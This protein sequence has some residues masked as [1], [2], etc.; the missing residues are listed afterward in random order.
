M[1]CKYAKTR[2]RHQR[3][4]FK[5]VHLFCAAASLH[6]PQGTGPRVEGN[7]SAAFFR[8]SCVCARV[9]PPANAE[10]RS[11]A[12][13]TIRHVC[14]LQLALRRARLFSV[15]NERQGGP[16]HKITHAPMAG[17]DGGL[18][19]QGKTRFTGPGGS[20]GLTSVFFVFELMGKL[21]MPCWKTHS[22]MQTGDTQ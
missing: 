17:E 21:E 8:R 1:I 5:G 7:A 9:A 15:N 18:C 10:A 6:K 11:V 22:C 20:Q 14:P 12:S 3:N 16:C 13:L 2:T 4:P 19:I